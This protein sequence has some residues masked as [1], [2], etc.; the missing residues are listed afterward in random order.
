MLKSDLAGSGNV[1]H[2]PKFYW[3][4]CNNMEF[5]VPVLP[6]AI[7]EKLEGFAQS[8][9]F[10]AVWFR[11]I[12]RLY[13][14]K[15]IPQFLREWRVVYGVSLEPTGLG[16]ERKFNAVFLGGRVAMMEVYGSTVLLDLSSSVQTYRMANEDDPHWFDHSGI[17]WSCRLS[18]SA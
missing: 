13:R 3:N 7:M 15:P 12:V 2:H 6:G 8:G 5:P 11:S 1:E 17:L 18:V 10:R 4:G 14:L 16:V 9:K